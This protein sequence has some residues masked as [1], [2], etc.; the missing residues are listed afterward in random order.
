MKRSFQAIA[1]F[2]TALFFCVSAFA[3][4]CVFVGGTHNWS[5][6][7]GWTGCG[8]VVPGATDDALVGT[9]SG[10]STTG[11]LTIDGVSG[12]P[13]KA[14]SVDF[15]SFTG[16]LSQAASK[17]LDVGDPAGSGA[18]IFKLVTGMSYSPNITGTVKFVST[19]GV[20]ALTFAGKQMP[21]T[22]FDGVGGSWQF[23]DALI[24]NGNITITL[25]NGALD[26]NGQ[27]VTGYNFSSSN[28]NTRSLTLGTTTWTTVNADTIWDIGTSTNMT[29]SAGSSTIVLVQSS[30]PFTFN[31]GGLTYGTLQAT[32]LTTNT[33]TITGN[34]TFTTLTTSIGAN[35][36]A[37]YQFGGNQTITGTWTFN[38]NSVLNRNYISSTV[39]GTQRTITAAAI[40]SNGADLQD[41]IGAGA[42][43]WNLSGS[44]FGGGDAGNNSGITL[45]TPKNCFMVT[46]VSVN[47]SA[48]NWK[49]TSGGSTAITPVYP[50]PQDTAIFDSNSVT[51]TG[52]TITIDA[53]AVRIP[54]MNW[55]GVANTPA[56]AWTNSAS[57]FGNVTYVSG[58]TTSGTGTATLEGRG[59]Q[60]FTTAGITIAHR[61]VTNNPG[62][63]YTQQDALSS[64]NNSSFV[65]VV[66]GT[67][68]A[69][70]HNLTGTGTNAVLAI[71]GGTLTSSAT[72]S[73][74]G[75]S[76]GTSITSGTLDISTGVFTSPG[77]LT[78]TGGV[79]KAGTLTHTGALT[80]SGTALSIGTGG[81]TFTTGVLTITGTGSIGPLSGDAITSITNTAITVAGASG[82]GGSYTF[83]Q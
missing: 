76:S 46:A 61:I 35:V 28:S 41:I 10:G 51:T 31:G 40:S 17:E 77:T 9:G 2:L 15:T 43:T 23:Q 63:S 62:G 29:L 65:Q 75:A 52:K 3:N 1:I 81:A 67:W 4:T 42:A 82:A 58:M 24:A 53:S 27:T 39:K 37:N 13:S 6:T 12:T 21:I 55:T 18:G 64:S 36:S 73:V 68:A 8:G 60:T 70:T 45:N 30:N 34:N 20:N 66:A 5:D 48:S 72:I 22:T 32:G 80:T 19:T 38:S 47:W 33:I 71:S 79:F 59:A 11:T 54:G 26:T 69:G 44:T 16:T 78:M 7:T 50:L 57:V 83:V 49:T 74:S 56:L 25:N 14:R